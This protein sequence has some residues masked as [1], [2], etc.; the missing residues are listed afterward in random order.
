MNADHAIDNELQSRQS[1]AAVR[2]EGKI[3]RPVRVAHIH[4]DAHRGV[5]EGV[6]LDVL[7]FEVEHA[8]VNKAFLTLGA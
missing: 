8:L 2:Q 6:E 1:H 5:G 3:E 7:L 4:H